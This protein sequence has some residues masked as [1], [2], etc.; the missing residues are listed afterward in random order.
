VIKL[1]SRNIAVVLALLIAVSAGIY[2][3]IFSSGD[4][5]HTTLKDIGEG[6]IPGRG[7][8]VQSGFYDTLSLKDFI[9]RLMTGLSEISE[10]EGT[11]E[12][13]INLVNELKVEL[14]SSISGVD[15]V[16][17]Q[18]VIVEQIRKQ[19]DLVR[20]L[21]ENGE[22]VENILNKIKPQRRPN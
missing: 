18:V 2:F 10:N 9:I 1:N 11:A 14:N 7:T 21:A 17:D 19:L 22:S 16:E 13:I 5:E 4:N 8:G 6:E 12:D 20:E 15:L 3:L